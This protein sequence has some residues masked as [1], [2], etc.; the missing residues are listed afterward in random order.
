MPSTRRPFAEGNE[1]Q[2]RGEQ[3][4]EVAEQERHALERGLLRDVL[5]LLERHARGLGDLRVDRRTAARDG[6]E[7]LREAIRRRPQVLD[8]GG[9]RVAPGQVSKNVQA[10]RRGHEVHEVHVGRRTHGAHEPAREALVEPDRARHTGRARP[11]PGHRLEHA[12]DRPAQLAAGHLDP[13]PQVAAAQLAGHVGADH[14]RPLARL[15]PLATR[16]VVEHPAI[17][18]KW[19]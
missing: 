18:A 8:R 11:G 16:G 10:A 2:R 9:V 6:V 13:Q 4:A 12:G 5:A 14:A 1:E 3:V 19:K 7:Q 15:R 17:F